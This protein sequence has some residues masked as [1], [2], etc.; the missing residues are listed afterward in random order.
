MLHLTDGAKNLLDQYFAEKEETSS[1][2]VF[3]SPGCGGP[4]LGLAL[5]EQKETDDVFDLRGYTFLV[6]KSLLEVA[7]PIEV[8]G[9]T[10]GFNISS[11][12]S[13]QPG[14]GGCGSCSCC[15]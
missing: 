10:N 1:I 3:M 4:Q 13:T 15:S 7:S 6:D 5:D 14:A 12:L 8:D 11:K 2:R 9:S